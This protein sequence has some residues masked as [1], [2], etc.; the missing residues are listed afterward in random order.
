MV[1]VYIALPRYS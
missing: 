1:H